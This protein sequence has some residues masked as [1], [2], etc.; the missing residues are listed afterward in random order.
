MA[1]APVAVEEAITG[2]LDRARFSG[3]HRI[4]M[5]T[6]LAAVIFDSAK[7]F[8]LSFVI[9]GMRAMWGLSEVDASYLAVFGLTGTIVGSVFWGW[10]ADRIGRRATLLWTIAIFSLTTVCGFALEYW[11]SLLACLVMGF[12]VGGALPI[13]F[14]LTAE[15][16]PVKSRAKWLLILAILGSTGGY[17]LAALIAWGASSVYA[18]AFAWRLI[19]LIQ[20]VPAALIFL[21]LARMLPESPRYLLAK[22]RVEEARA[23]AE[24]L[25]GPITTDAAVP[26]EQGREPARAIHGPALYGRTAALAVFAFGWG[27]ANFGFVT[28]LPTLLRDLGYTGASS[29][30]YLALS[31]LIALPALAITGYLLTTWSTRRTLIAYA[32]GG[33]ISMLALG[34][35]ASAGRLTPPFLV[36]V[37]GLIFFF[38]TSIG[39]VFSLYAAE[40]FPTRMRARRS[41]YLAGAGKLGGVIGPY[42]GGVWLGA[43]GSALGLH[44]PLAAALVAAAI[45]LAIAGV[46]T[47]G[48]SL[49][50]IHGRPAKVPDRG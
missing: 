22:D 47:R 45:A 16:L 13:A 25:V 41:G 26:M 35:G 10:L 33:A 50:Q 1:V 12:G 24:S 9:P 27:I 48:L 49:E 2:A 20:L 44:A 4:L 30:A 28:W 7:P 32:L 40:V 46:E 36:V 23:A 31:A 15:Y 29:S 11:Q 19:W 17:A 34:L 43:G 6:V 38:V 5:A 18:D 37:A 39:G 42:F 21:L 3:R 8:S 14:A